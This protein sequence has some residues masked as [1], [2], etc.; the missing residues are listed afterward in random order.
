M[1]KALVGIYFIVF[2]AANILFFI[3]CAKAAEKARFS[4]K[5]LYITV[6]CNA[7]FF[8]Y[9][10]HAFSM[11]PTVIY[12]LILLG[13]IIELSILFKNHFL[14]ILMYSIKAVLYVLCFQ[15]IVISSGVLI[16]GCPLGDIF[17]KAIL[18][19][20]LIIISWALCALVA[21]IMHL[22]IPGKYLKIINQNTEQVLFILGFLCAAT[23]YL[24]FN[25][26]IYAYVHNFDIVYLPLNQII[27]P[28][29]W[30]IV[31]VLSTFVLI[32]FDHLHGYKVKSDVLE[33]TLEEQKS[34]L[35]ATKSLAERDS[36]VDAYNRVTAET[37]ISD[38]LHEVENGALFILDVDNFKGINDT[39]GHPFGDKVLTFLAK[40]IASVFR[41]D[42]IIGRLGGDEF[43]VFQKSAPTLE[44]V[45]EKA[46]NLCKDINVPFSDKDGE[47]VSVTISIGIALT[48][49]NGTDFK[50][51]YKHADSALYE[52]KRSGKNTF[53]FY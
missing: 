9:I 21:L 32:R 43:I 39:K 20:V 42:D 13:C 44:L 50:T 23:L 15:S 53:T 34:M 22:T 1:S 3:I 6:F 29:T 33:K 10:T 37:K 47:S 25:S 14:G 30:L 16:L 12:L 27:G 31:I 26:F 8:T 48:P 2:Y 46:E 36:L 4:T 45:K 49:Q 38:C 24:V 35:V 17:S 28:V 52:S 5:A 51:L 11:P 41:E 18:L 40:R 7:L 19:D